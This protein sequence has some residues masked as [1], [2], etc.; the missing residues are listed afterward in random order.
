METTTDY[1]R[2]YRPAPVRV[3]NAVGRG[4]DR[5]R[6]DPRLDVGTMLVRARKRTGLSDYGDDWFLEPLRVLVD[7]ING[8]AQLTPVGRWIQRQRIEA[9]L[10]TRLRLED[11][12]RRHPEIHD[13]DLGGVIV[14]AGLQ[15]TG[16][17][18]LH[19]LIASHPKVRAVTAWEG[20]N[21]LP[22]PGDRPDRPRARLRR[23]RWAERGIAYLAPAF[24]AVHPAEHDAPEEDVLLLDLCFMS[25]S[26]E[27]TM[28]VPSY[29]RWLAGQDHT[30]C[31]EYFRT[32][33]RALA[34]QRPTRHWVL[35]TPH[36]LEYLDVLLAVFPQAIVA[37]T[38][39][40]PGQCVASFCSMVAH[41]R[42][43][44]SDR[45]DPR[46][47]AAHW[48]RKIRNMVDRAAAVRAASDSDRFVDVSYY[49]LLRD[50]IAQLRRIHERAGI[51][52]GHD[53]LRAAE[54]TVRHNPQHRYGRHVYDPASFGL[55]A[56]SIERCFGSY[57]ER[58]AIP[59]ERADLASP[60]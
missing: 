47:V 52:F 37:Q 13:I 43:V 58:H 3:L 9:A 18:T 57:R 48:V 46:E 6:A 60:P 27:A 38:H 15:R 42:G 1:E 40:D 30:R 32:V 29:S 51:P 35:K 39:R 4:I 10:A 5:F 45:V 53:V 20:M 50:P 23:A 8:E 54:D 28:Q 26:A 25:Q 56:E 14:I 19:R 16:T 44:F 36:H 2:P 33:L 21:P 34:W 17:T 7:S 11:L 22:L 41:G 55:T 31:Y 59:R 24:F 49:E 12:L